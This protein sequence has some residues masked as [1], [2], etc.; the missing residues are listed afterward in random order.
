MNIAAFS[1]YP[2][3][4]AFIAQINKYTVICENLCRH[5]IKRHGQ[6]RPRR[7]TRSL[8]ESLY[9]ARYRYAV[10]ITAVRTQIHLVVPNRSAVHIWINIPA[11]AVRLIQIHSSEVIPIAK[12]RKHRIGLKQ[13]PHVIQP[14]FPIIK[15]QKQCKIISG[16]HLRNLS[17]AGSKVFRHFL[18]VSSGQIIRYA[19]SHN[20]TSFPDST[21][22]FSGSM[23][24]NSCRR[25]ANS[26]FSKS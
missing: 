1:K 16:N 25:V 8:S 24:N 12:R 3:P 23:A 15:A 11:D 7:F 9:A 4:L 26:Q 17:A 2:Y 14:R 19:L 20:R 13:R 18:I 21:V 10:H 5:T 6:N 22:Y